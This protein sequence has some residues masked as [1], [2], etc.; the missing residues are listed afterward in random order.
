MI[1]LVRT[2]HILRSGYAYN[3]LNDQ[4]NMTTVFEQAGL[5]FLFNWHASA[6]V[7]GYEFPVPVPGKYRVILNSDDAQFGGFDRIDSAT[8]YF[9]T[10]RDGVHY[11]RV[12]NVSRSAL[13]FEL[14]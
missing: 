1:R 4:E 9:T 7:M 5:I 12:Y 2:H 6:S 13:V 3:L 11:L 10:Q 14:A 8:E